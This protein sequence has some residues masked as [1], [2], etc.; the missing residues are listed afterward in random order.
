MENT[1]KKNKSPLVLGVISLFAWFIPI[2]GIIT[3]IVGLILS[4]KSRKI[5][6]CK[7]YDI[8]IVLNIIGIILTVANFAIGFYLIYS[9]IG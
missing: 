7:A 2:I 1:I 5:D 9:K 3:S 4:I 6:K 8:A